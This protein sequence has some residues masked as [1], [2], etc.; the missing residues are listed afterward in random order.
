[1]DC[2][3]VAVEGE[4][5][6]GEEEEGE[7]EEGEEELECYG[8]EDKKK[9]EDYACSCDEGEV[10]CEGEEYKLGKDLYDAYCARCHGYE[11]DGKGEASNFTYPKPRDFTYGIFKFHSTASGE[12]PTDDDLKLGILRGY[13]GTSM[14]GWKGKFMD[15]ELE[16]LIGYIKA[17]P[18]D[19]FEEEGEL[20]EIGE[21][22]PVSDKLIKTGIE[23]YEKAK[24]WECHGKFGRGD[25]EKGW[26]PNF[27]DDW[28]DKIWPTNLV[29][30]WEL[31]NG[32]SLK[33]LFRSISTGLDGTPMPSFADSYS[34]EQ[35]WGIAHYLKSLQIIRK[36]GS[37]VVIK[38]TDNI[39]SS[40]NDALWEKSDYVDL[41]MEGKKVFGMTLLSMITNMRVR[42]LYSGSEIAI[43]LEW[44]DKK[45]DKGDGDF[46][47]DAVRLQFPVKRNLIN[48]W[49]WSASDNSVTEFNASGSNMNES[50]IQEKK[51]VEAVSSYT[52][53]VY[54]LILKRALNT[55]DNN[56]VIFRFNNRIPFS[57]AAYDGKNNEKGS[58]GALSSVRYL[59][60][61]KQ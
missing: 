49:Y 1:M 52:Y 32:S 40:T 9:A 34:M 33:D 59:L 43:M 36:F 7:E 3:C 20:I 8:P 16:A 2:K 10:Y 46:P 15:T 55:G 35:R 53:G 14:F 13:P 60:I 12:P 27:K 29:H 26:Q 17:F 21:P 19:A 57:I 25:G 42:G 45:P 5:E 44:L 38:K 22:P 39:P 61:K 4:E 48:L 30:P 56:D 54:R 41:R 28:G 18:E 50:S 11:G 31:R 23:I 47:P 37:T 58:R 6:E 24:C 51:D